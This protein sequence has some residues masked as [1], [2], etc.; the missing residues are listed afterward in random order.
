M[1]IVAAVLAGCGDGADSHPQGGASNAGGGG[2]GAAAP[3]ASLRVVSAREVGT[4]PRSPWVQGRDG[5]TSGLAFGKSVWAYGDTV[6][7]DPG[8]DGSNWHTNS[9]GYADPSAWRRGFV[10]PIDA[11]GAPRYYV[12]L[13]E[14]ERA[15]DALHAAEDCAEPPCGV[16]WA[17]WPSEP[18]AEPGADRAWILYGLFNDEHPSG[19]GVASWSGLDQPVVRRRVGEGW[20][21]FPSPE[22]EWAN[23]PVVHEGHLYTFACT[24]NGFSSP[25]Q[26]ARV[27]MDRVDE[28]AAWRFFDGAAWST[29]MSD[30]ADLFEAGSIMSAA[31]S[32]GLQRWLAVYSPPLDRAIYARTAEAL[33]GPWSDAVMLFSVQGDEPYDAVHHQELSEDG[34]RTQ[35]VTFSRPVGDTWFGAEH[36]IWRVELALR[37]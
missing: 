26:L 8:A 12:E 17:L 4:V 28:R 14:E 35:Y 5:G 24:R 10:E 31:Y 18:L 15:W 37:P 22:P 27:P 16:R 2:S 32:P 6:L 33:E 1:M 13:T 21:L 3:S 29:T 7:N 23:A 25:C 20:L 9:F 19:I 34:G 30:A 36:V 11:V